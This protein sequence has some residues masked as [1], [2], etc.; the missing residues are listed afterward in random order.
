MST[1]L[2]QI[3][4]DLNLSTTWQQPEPFIYKHYLN[5]CTRPIVI[6]TEFS[7]A[8]GKI[9]HSAQETLFTAFE[10]HVSAFNPM[11]ITFIIH[12]S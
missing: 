7:S 2:F 11:Q 1:C 10:K 5:M 6:M 4:L 8:T 12:T 3:A 9:L